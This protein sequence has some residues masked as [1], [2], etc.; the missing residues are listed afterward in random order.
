MEII[1][2]LRDRIQEAK[3]N[4]WLGEVQYLEAS[5]HTAVDS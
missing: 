2:N 3:L 5:L 1:A 4:R